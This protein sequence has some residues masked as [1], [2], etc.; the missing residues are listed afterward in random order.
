MS[1]THEHG[2][3]RIARISKEMGVERLI[4]MSAMNA[5]PEYRPLWNSKV[6][7][8]SKKCF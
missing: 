5:D 6:F 4:H 2:A 7:F 8:P 3:R 1:E